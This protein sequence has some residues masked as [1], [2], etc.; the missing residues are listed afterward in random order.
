MRACVQAAVGQYVSS[1]H[2][3]G[4]D[5]P[6]SLAALYVETLLDQVSTAVSPSVSS[7]APCS[8]S[9]ACCWDSRRERPVHCCDLDAEKGKED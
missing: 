4:I 6:P 7:W 5:V 3:Y 8:C 1:C 2:A 9:W